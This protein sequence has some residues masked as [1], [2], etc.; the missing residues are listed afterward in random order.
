M[1]KRPDLMVIGISILGIALVYSLLF[2]LQSISN[3][4]EQ[5]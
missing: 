3:N 1:K 4:E 5:R 2:R